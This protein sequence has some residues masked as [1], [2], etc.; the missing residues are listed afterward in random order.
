[1]ELDWKVKFN[2]YRFSILHMSIKSV[3]LAV[4]ESVYM[5]ELESTKVI[6]FLC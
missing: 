5:H 2:L 3:R 6:N 4:N 1:M